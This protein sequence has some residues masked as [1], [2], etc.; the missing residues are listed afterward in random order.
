M[1]WSALCNGIMNSS[2]FRRSSRS[3]TT[4]LAPSRNWYHPVPRFLTTLGML[5]SNICQLPPRLHRQPHNIAKSG[6]RKVLSL[7]LKLE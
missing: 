6:R 3:G 1:S 2:V 4:H 5:W 7:S